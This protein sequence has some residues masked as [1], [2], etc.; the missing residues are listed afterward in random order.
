[1]RFSEVFEYHK[2][3][4]WYNMYL[5][6]KSLKMQIEVFKDGCKLYE[7]YQKDQTKDKNRVKNIDQGDIE[8]NN[9]MPTA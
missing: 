3:P 9:G 6:Y 4:E 8:M 7:S 5:D 2:I 1:M